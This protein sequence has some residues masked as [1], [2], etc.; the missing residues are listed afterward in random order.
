MHSFDVVVVGGGPAGVVAATQAGRAGTRTLLVE[1]SSR[2]GGVTINAGINRPG[3]FH[4]WGK[5]V[6]AGIGWELVER[7]IHEAGGEMPDFADTTLPFTEHQPIVDPWVYAH[8]CDEFVLDAGCTLLLHTMLAQATQEPHGRWKLQLCTKDGPQT[9]IATQLIDCTGD[10]NAVTLAGL[11]VHVHKKTQPATLACHLT[12]YDVESLDLDA[13]NTAFRAAVDRGEL[14]ASDGSWH[15]DR[16]DVTNFLKGY[17]RN[18]N[19]VSVPENAHVSAA[20]TALEVE[21]RRSVHRMVQFL[22]HQPGLEDLRV[23]HVSPEVGVRETVTIHGKATITA[24]DYLSGKV[25]EDALCYSFYPIDLHGLDTDAWHL[26]QLH[27]G[28]VATIPRRAL[29]PR[30]SHNL[31]VAGR[32]LSSDRLANSAARVQASAMAMG[33]TAGALAYLAATAGCDPE[34]VPLPTAR[35]LLEKHHAVVPG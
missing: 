22:R 5:Q 20:R 12:G 21:G 29:L 3:L 6:I 23:L 8:L 10:A 13:I 33:Q 25:W 27:P 34:D 30:N 19:H 9:V 32:C 14:K 17:G 18:S 28:T 24:E 26:Q 7:T 16:P 35:A 2:L 1:R 4:A 31:V 11:P 15:I